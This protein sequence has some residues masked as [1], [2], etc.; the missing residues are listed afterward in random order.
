VRGALSVDE[1]WG[2]RWNLAVDRLA[3]GGGLVALPRLILHRDT[4]GPR[5]DGALYAEV[6]AQWRRESL[7]QHRATADVDAG[8]RQL[9][10]VLADERVAEL[11][12][13]HGLVREYVD[14][15]ET[16]RALLARIEEDGSLAWVGEPPRS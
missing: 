6:V 4:A 11:V 7:T 13:A 15:Y 1:P 9:E 3:E 5:A 16:G 10:R 8:L 14:D 12:I 2:E